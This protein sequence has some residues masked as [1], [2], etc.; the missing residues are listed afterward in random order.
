MTTFTH[1]DGYGDSLTVEA[2]DH[3]TRAAVRSEHGNAV[4]VCRDEAPAVALAILDAVGFVPRFPGNGQ[5][6]EG[7]LYAAAALLQEAVLEAAEADLDPALETEAL[8]L[9][10]AATDSCYASFP[11][12]SVRACWT[13]AARR[14]REIHS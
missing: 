7:K 12:E 9:L 13:R 8:A 4:Y 3:S 10:N 11:N 5:I 6:G 14:A 2:E 1:T